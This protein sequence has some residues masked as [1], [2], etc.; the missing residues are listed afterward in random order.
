MRLAQ[1][2]KTHHNI[3]HIQQQH[4]QQE[5]YQQLRVK[6]ARALQRKPARVFSNGTRLRFLASGSPN[7]VPPTFV[8]RCPECDYKLTEQD[9]LDGFTDNNVDF[10]TECP[11]C[12]HRFI[13]SATL[14]VFGETAE[15]PCLCA[16]QT[17]DQ[18]KL[19]TR[20][21]KD[22]DVTDA[23]LVNEIAIKRP[24]LAWNAYWH[25][26][27]EG[28]EED[29]VADVIQFFLFG[30]L[31]QEDDIDPFAR[32][33]DFIPLPAPGAS[34]I[35]PSFEPTFGF[36]EVGFAE[37][38][39]EGGLEDGMDEPEVGYVKMEEH[40]DVVLFDDEPT[41]NHGPVIDEEDE[42]K[43]DKKIKHKISL[44]KIGKRDQISK[45]AVKRIATKSG[46]KRVAK[47]GTE[48]IQTLTQIFVDDL[49]TSSTLVMNHRKAK[50]LKDKD[51]DLV[52]KI[53]RNKSGRGY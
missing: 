3:K 52:M 42:E 19:F 18:V 46:A 14:T 50:T 36:A 35:H 26:R 17:R 53:W 5:T 39:W 38:V 13:T 30:S 11:E 24:E 20:D 34:P 6:A 15:F 10:T 49:I 25:G 33:A 28:E 45:A 31:P 41:N 47:K 23:Q 44:P 7:N 2:K 40:D 43:E 37:A 27:D 21:Y 4:K 8:G 16:E 9:I 29:R 51:A 48:R 22:L 12:Y 1:K 32:S